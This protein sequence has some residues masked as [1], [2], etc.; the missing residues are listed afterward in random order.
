MAV[1]LKSP[2]NPINTKDSKKNDQLFSI[3]LTN[4]KITKH[5]KLVTTYSFEN[6][7]A[8]SIFLKSIRFCAMVKAA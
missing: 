3:K 6:Y 2:S 5:K 8:F 7:L 1:S 4:S